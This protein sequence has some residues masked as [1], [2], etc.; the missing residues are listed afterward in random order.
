MSP[1][2][3]SEVCREKVNRLGVADKEEIRTIATHE[4]GRYRVKRGVREPVSFKIQPG[5][6]QRSSHQWRYYS[7]H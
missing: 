1:L 6:S 4:R 3:R 5:A 7:G 2:L